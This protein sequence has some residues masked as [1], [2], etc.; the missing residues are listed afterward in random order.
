V[1]IHLQE[2]PPESRTDF[3]SSRLALETMRHQLVP[4]PMHYESTLGRHRTTLAVP[5]SF[6]ATAAHHRLQPVI[7]YVSNVDLSVQYRL[8]NAAQIAHAEGRNV[9][10]ICSS[11]KSVALSLG[12]NP[13]I[14]V[15]G[16]ESEDMPSFPGRTIITALILI[17]LNG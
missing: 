17:D 2:A 14:R 1:E 5:A 7:Q 10:E 4:A 11:I 8:S 12:F 15:Q 6:D 9:Y 13:I 3:S 16:V